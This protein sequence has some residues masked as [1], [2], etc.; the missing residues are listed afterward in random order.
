MVNCVVQ[1]LDG[2]DYEVDIDVSFMI[3]LVP[4]NV[5]WQEVQLLL[6]KPTVTTK[7]QKLSVINPSIGLW[8]TEALQTTDN[9][10]IYYSNNT[11]T[12]LVLRVMRKKRRAM[13]LILAIFVQMWKISCLRN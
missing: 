12:Q 3:I 9:S 11:R 13:Y 1:L 5:T 4:Y 2:T 10:R 6:R 7:S 8:D